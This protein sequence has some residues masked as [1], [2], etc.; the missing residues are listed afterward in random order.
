MQKDITTWTTGTTPGGWYFIASPIQG[1]IDPSTVG[2]ITDNLG[3]TATTANATYDLYKY[4]ATNT[5]TPW[6][7][8][9]A[10][11]DNFVLANGA[12]YLY[13]NAAGQTF[14]FSGE[15]NPYST[16]DNKVTLANTGW[17]LI[18]NPFSCAVTVDKAFSE[19]N[20]GTA[21]SNQSAGSTIY[22]CRGIAV[23]GN[24]GDEVTFAKPVVNTPGPSNLNIVLA[25]Q[26]VTRSS[27]NEAIIDNAVISFN[28]S[29]GLPKFTLFEGNAKLYIPQG[30]E[31]Y[32]IVSAEAQGEMPV[33]F[34]A[35]VDGEYTLT[36]N[37]EDVEMNYLH[38]IDNLTGA[39]IDLRANPSYT[40]NGSTMD[41]P[42]RFRL[43]FSANN[44]NN[45]NGNDNF[46]FISNGQ[47]VLTEQGNAMV[48]D[49][50]G[51]LIS[52]HN[53]ASHITTEGMAAGVYVLQLVNGSDVKTQKIVVR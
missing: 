12:G 52:S 6:I 53:N 45:E 10:H 40:F 33:N 28:E 46:A 48:Y 1:T 32:A 7:N 25:Q 43:M 42:S 14:E 19:L 8:Y 4:D 41:Y 34:V 38:L 24:A 3:S 30:T 49:I 26:I 47:I 2:L 21:V 44:A 13:A 35:T 27:S 36:V 17:N 29:E 39:D 31:E 5:S 11:T 22:P 50:T 51:R 37:A 16:T 23:Y 18:G 15:I 20:N 9:R